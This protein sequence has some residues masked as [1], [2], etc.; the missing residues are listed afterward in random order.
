VLLLIT[1]VPGN[2]I[3][4][5][6]TPYD[7]IAHFTLYGLFAVLLTRDMVQVTGLWRATLLA[8]AIAVMFGAADEWHQRFVPQRRP[9]LADLR[10][11]ALGAAGGAF[12]FALYLRDRRARITTPR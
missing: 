6:L 1:S 8:I 2:A 10:A 5:Q 11:D 9:G 3:P 12:L 4:Q 7:K